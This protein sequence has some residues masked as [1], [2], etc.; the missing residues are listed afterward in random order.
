MLGH[1][2]AQGA[3]RSPAKPATQSASVEHAFAYLLPSSGSGRWPLGGSAHVDFELAP[4]ASTTKVRPIA[5]FVGSPAMR[6][7]YSPAGSA[8]M[9]Q[10]LRMRLQSPGQRG[11]GSG[12]QVLEASE[13]LMSFP[14]TLTLQGSTVVKQPRQPSLAVTSM[15]I[16]VS[17]GALPGTQATSAARPVV[18][19]DTLPSYP[20]GGGSPSRPASAFG[21]VEP[22]SVVP[23]QAY[24]RRVKPRADE[25]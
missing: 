12:V 11:A 13:T 18:T 24:A 19:Q 2:P 9:V 5:P 16:A 25:S 10:V 7:A 21:G 1:P 22:L 20:I 3:Q 6:T 23:P 15:V 8:G 4:A 14:E 17:A